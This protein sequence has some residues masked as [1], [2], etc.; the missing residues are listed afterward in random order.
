MADAKL[1]VVNEYPPNIDQINAVLHVKKQKNII[2]TYGGKIYAPDGTEVTQDL[3]EHESVHVRQHERHGGS[4][5][6]WERYLRDVDFR[7]GQEV[8]AYRTQL[9]WIDEHENRQ[10]RRQMREHICATLA[11]PMYGNMLSKKQAAK[12]LL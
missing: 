2:Y 12:L 4:D 5:A 8:E 6:W 1:E 3:Q 7:L 11:A 9:C 10:T